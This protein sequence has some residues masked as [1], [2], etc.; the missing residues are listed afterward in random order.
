MQKY[1][2]GFASPPTLQEG[3]GTEVQRNSSVSLGSAKAGAVCGARHSLLWAVTGSLALTAP[4]DKAPALPGGRR[5]FRKG[6]AGRSVKLQEGADNL[7]PQNAP[8]APARV[9]LPRL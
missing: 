6:R 1:S 2:K 5:G 4:S 7:D 9:P 3:Q 8:A